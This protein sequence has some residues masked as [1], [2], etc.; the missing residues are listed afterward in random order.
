[1]IHIHKMREDIFT[2]FHADNIKELKTF[3]SSTIKEKIKNNDTPAVS[4]R[5]EEFGDQ[6]QYGGQMGQIQYDTTFS[7]A[8][9]DIFYNGKCVYTS[10]TLISAIRKLDRLNITLTDF[11]NKNI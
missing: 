4:F 2:D 9:W 7:R 6:L 10:Y 5:V 11:N 3:I 1:M 8:S